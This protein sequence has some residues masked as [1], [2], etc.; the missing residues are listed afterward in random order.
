MK[1]CIGIPIYGDVPAV[2]LAAISTLIAQAPVPASIKLKV[3]DSLVSRARNSLV[4][5]FLEMPD[6]THILFIDSDLGFT[7]ED[8]KRITSHNVSVV[9]GWY[10]L[11]RE[12]SEVQWCG[13]GALTEEPIHPN[14]L[15]RVRYIGTGFLCIARSVFEEI[16]E[17]DGPQIAYLADETHRP[18]HDFF[19]VG[20]RDT[21]TGRRYL[22]E[23]WAFCQRWLDLGG[24]V[25][26]DTHVRLR[27]HGRITWPLA[28]QSA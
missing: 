9:G 12:G 11:K 3:G 27:H 23:D 14:G 2:F 28:H 5:D 25:F 1:V 17:V 22:S 26:A 19:Q 13:N 24:E 6:C 18:E 21:A 15:Q 7:A 20:V 10:P 16:I 8:V 4:A